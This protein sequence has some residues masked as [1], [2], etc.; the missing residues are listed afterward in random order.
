MKY[1][2]LTIPDELHTKFKAHCVETGR[3]MQALIVDLMANEVNNGNKVNKV[4]TADK[5]EAIDTANTADTVNMLAGLKALIE[6]LD[7]ELK[8]LSS[9]L[10]QVES[11]KKPKP[12]PNYKPEVLEI[13]HIL[14]NSQLTK[15]LSDYK[16]S[17]GRGTMGSGTLANHRKEHKNDMETHQQ[18]LKERDPHGLIWEY[19]EKEKIYIVVEKEESID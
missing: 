13:G 1:F 6:G 15:R 14:N 2:K 4:D 18:W 19:K 9:R 7:N 11:R 10:D 16:I 17:L 8:S 3:S 12:D 5:G